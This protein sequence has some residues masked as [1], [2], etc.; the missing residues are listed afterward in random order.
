MRCIVR[1][2]KSFRCIFIQFEWNIPLYEVHCT[3]LLSSSQSLSTYIAELEKK[4]QTWLGGNHR[5]LE[6]HYLVDSARNLIVTNLSCS[7]VLPP[8]LP[9]TS[10]TGLTQRTAGYPRGTLPRWFCPMPTWTTSR[11]RSTWRES[12]ESMETER[13]ENQDQLAVHKGWKVTK[14]RTKQ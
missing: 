10:S 1:K 14:D 3:A 2:F 7:P 8:V 12:R 4:S 13:W 6:P 5:S 11:G 9:Y